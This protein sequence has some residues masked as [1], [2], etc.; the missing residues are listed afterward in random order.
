MWIVEVALRRPYTFLIMALL[1]LLATPLVLLK[2]S[3][4]IFSEI[5]ITVIS[6][7]SS[8]TALSAQEIGNRIT[9]VNE[10]SLTTTVNDIEHI[11]SE[12]ISG[13]SIIKIFFQPN[14]NIPPAISQ[15]A[16]M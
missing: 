2:M 6:I 14:A 7:A 4:D 3:T 10:R 9:A 11:E 15:V 12:S 16:A 13:F 1:I 5:N 8:Y